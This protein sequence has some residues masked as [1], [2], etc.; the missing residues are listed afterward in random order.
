[1]FIMLFYYHHV[2]WVPDVYY[3]V[4]LVSCYMGA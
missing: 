2:I 1:M 4:L 3:V